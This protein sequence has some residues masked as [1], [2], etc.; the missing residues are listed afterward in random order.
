M[1]RSRGVQEVLGLLPEELEPTA[2]AWLERIHPRD[3]SAA[4]M[5][6]S[7]A[8]INGRGWATTYRVRDAKGRYK[9]ILE[10]A[11]VQR[12]IAGDPV[13]A[14]GC[15]VDVSE[16]KRL[17]D[18]LEETQRIAKIGGWEYSYATQE[19]TWTDEMYRIF[20]AK[21]GEFELILGIHARAVRA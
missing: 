2:E 18:I 6:I 1:H 15:C 21:R 17:T 9:S 8:L 3:F 10:R 14:I 7:A 11:L 5:A 20:G 16:I 12:N 4:K 19:L 13:R